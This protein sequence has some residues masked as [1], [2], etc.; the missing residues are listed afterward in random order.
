MAGHLLP[1]DGSASE[2]ALWT[3]TKAGRQCAA[4]ARMTEAGLLEVRIAIDGEH[5]WSQVYRVAL[6]D[7]AMAAAEQKR[8][9]FIAKGWAVLRGG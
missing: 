9:E 8:D 4:T 6:G 1:F 7:E 3:L 5:C 2:H